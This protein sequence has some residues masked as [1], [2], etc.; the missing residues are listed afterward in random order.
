MRIDVVSIFPE[1]FTPFFTGSILG[2]GQKAGLLDLHAHDLRQWTTD[3]HR[4]VDD[5]PFG[6]GP[7]MV[8]K[9]EPFHH[10]V[11]AI[12][13]ANPEATVALLAPSGEPFS[14]SMAVELSQK[15]GLILLCGRYEGVDERVRTTL[16]DRAISVG[17]YVTAGGEAPALVV[18]EAVCRLVPGVLG[19]YSSTLDESHM[20]G[21]LE[22]PQYTRPRLFEGHDTPELLLN[23]D[24]AKIEVWRRK[25]A[26]IRTAKTRPDLLAQ[27]D[28]SDE[29]KQMVKRIVGESGS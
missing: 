3:K 4:T 7:G 22:Y 13:Q 28:L 14:Q 2:R 16:C 18:V 17:D 21:L 15:P 5:Y 8:M 27:A 23:G 10:A 1:F 11:T 9:V 20:D 26:I 24:H 12:K 29:E 19:E 25:Q 6:G